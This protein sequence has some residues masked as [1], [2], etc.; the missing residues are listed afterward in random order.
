MNTHTCWVYCSWW[1]THFFLLFGFDVDDEAVVGLEFLR[2]KMTLSFRARLLHLTDIIL[3]LF[4]FI[5]S[6]PW[7]RMVYCRPITVHPR[8]AGP[9]SGDYLS[10]GAGLD[11]FGF[12]RSIGHRIPQEVQPSEAQQVY[13][14]GDGPLY[15]A[16]HAK[17]SSSSQRRTFALS[18][19]QDRKVS[20]EIG[21]RHWL[22]LWIR[23]SSGHAMGVS[24]SAIAI[25]QIAW[26]G[27]LRRPGQITRKRRSLS[28]SLSIPN[29][30]FSVS[31]QLPTM[32]P[33]K[34]ITNARPKNHPAAP[35]RPTH[36]PMIFLCKSDRILVV[37]MRFD[38][39]GR[40]EKRE[41]YCSTWRKRRN[42]FVFLSSS[43][44]PN[45]RK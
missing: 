43:V 23:I 4:Y 27:R 34:K 21:H 19:H 7:R 36:R 28:L 24:S 10:V 14:S 40:G 35:T 44:S 26:R 8:I 17:L 3:N 15:R 16:V 5:F 13:G 37:S 18:H 38:L 2:I 9:E 29:Y 33:N 11:C 12:R 41:P 22:G 31:N 30:L 39:K 6:W 32:T 45:G 20:L 25:G 42:H 1:F